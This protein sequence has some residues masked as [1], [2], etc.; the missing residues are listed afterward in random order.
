M[1]TV[2]LPGRGRL[3]KKESGLF[4]HSLIMGGGIR[5]IESRLGTYHISY[6]TIGGSSRACSSRRQR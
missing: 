5:K 2:K 1:K 4:F 6:L 3:E